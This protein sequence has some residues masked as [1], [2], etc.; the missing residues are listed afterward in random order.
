MNTHDIEIELPP[1]PTPDFPGVVI[2]G[3]KAIPRYLFAG[4]QMAE[5]GQQCATAAIEAILQS[6]D[7]EDALRY[8]FIR[9]IVSASNARGRGSWQ[10]HYDRMPMPLNN[11]MKGSVA[12]HF[13]EAIDHGRRRLG[14]GRTSDGVRFCIETCSKESKTVLSC[15]NEKIAVNE[16]QIKDPR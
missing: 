10:F 11:P 7:R 8:R 6:Q 9:S 16:S 13:D 1:L 5:Y 14:D 2:K 4:N 3:M 12:Q 15:N